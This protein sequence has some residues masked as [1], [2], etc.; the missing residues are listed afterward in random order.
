MYGDVELVRGVFR[1]VQDLQGLP[2]FVN[3][4]FFSIRK[5]GSFMD[6]LQNQNA[7]RKIV[8]RCSARVEVFFVE[9]NALVSNSI[10]ISSLVLT[11]YAISYFI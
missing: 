3:V 9:I 6:I 4:G 7:H 10:L 8:N 5:F 1:C 2:P 11:G